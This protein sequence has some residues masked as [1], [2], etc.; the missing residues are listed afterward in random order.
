ME[1]LT[2]LLRTEGYKATGFT[3]ADSAVKFCGLNA[4]SIDTIVVDESMHNEEGLPLQF[5]L[6]TLIPDVTVITL[7]SQPEDDNSIQKPVDFEIL[8]EAVR[9]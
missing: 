2:E 9:R 7:S 1:L 5:A 6:R 3:D 4:S 8:L